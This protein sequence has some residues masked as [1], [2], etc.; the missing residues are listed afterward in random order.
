VVLSNK[1]MENLTKHIKIAA[2]ESLGT[3]KR[4]NRRKY[5]K[6]WDDQIKQLRETKK[7]YIK[8]PELKETRRPTGIQKKH[9]T[10]QMRSKKKTKTLL[11]QICYKSRTRHIQDNP[12]CTKF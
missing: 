4:R 10:G 6:I 8:M 9:C 2:S 3:I 5:L 1:G 7:N 12:K 11:G